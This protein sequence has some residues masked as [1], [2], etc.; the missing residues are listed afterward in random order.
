MPAPPGPPQTLEIEG[1]APAYY[2][3]P[4]AKGV[5]RP[6]VVYLHGRGA[7]PAQDCQKWA[8]VAREFGWVLCPSGQEDRGEGARGWGN[9]WPAAREA[10]DRAFAALAKKAGRFMQTRGNTLIGFSEG[11]YVAM[12]VGVREPEVYNRWLILAANDVYWGGEGNDELKKSRAKIK[13][14]YLLTGGQDGVVDNSRRVFDTLDA[15]RVHVIL[16]TPDDLGHE[17]P[18]ER[19]RELYHRPLKWLAGGK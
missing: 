9:N 5:K 3:P 13:R 19:M 1:S 16:R 12:N 17:V 10:V 6:V 2:Y 15:A 4:R 7:N 18:E 14:V 11:A 8:L